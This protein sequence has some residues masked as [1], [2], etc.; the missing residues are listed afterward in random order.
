M[1]GAVLVGRNRLNPAGMVLLKHAWHAVHA[2]HSSQS[3]PLFTDN[4]ATPPQYAFIPDGCFLHSASSGQRLPAISTMGSNGRIGQVAELPLPA[5]VGDASLAEAI[6]LWSEKSLISTEIIHYPARYPV[7]GGRDA[8]GISA[9]ESVFDSLLNE[10]LYLVRDLLQAERARSPTIDWYEA[11][12]DLRMRSDDD[13]ARHSMV[14]ELAD[15]LL[16]PLDHV[17]SH[18]KKALKR[19]RENQR[20]QLVQEVDTHCLMD[21]ASRPGSTMPEKAG[22]K[23]RILAVMREEAVDLLENR[24]ARH[25]S[26]LAHRA[27]TRYLAA[28]AHIHRS[29][30]KDRVAKLLRACVRV[31]RKPQFAG[32]GRLNHPCRNPNYVLLQNVH[33]APIWQAYTKLI[34]N[35]ELR[36]TLWRWPR[37]LWADRVAI[38]LGETILHWTRQSGCAVCVNTA[39]RIVQART[40]N[41]H[42]RW[43]LHDIMP[44]PIVVGRSYDSVGSMYIIDGPLAS[45]IDDR[46]QE[47]SLLNADYL[48]FW[49]SGKTLNLLPVYAVWPPPSSGAGAASNDDAQMADDVLECVKIF[50]RQ[51]KHTV[52]IGTLLVRGRQDSNSQLS[53]WQTFQRH[54]STCWTAD[55]GPE[56]SSWPIND[57]GRYH[58][59]TSLVGGC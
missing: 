24:V 10:S 25:C 13:P 3:I 11:L 39:D 38:Y 47:S 32:V 22:P 31:P 21:L 18:P 53:E 28:H 2:V 20:V 16:V 34:R 14:V 59:L 49:V 9:Y 46:L 43:L 33:Y 52:A 41:L 4:P 1:T 51:A 36:D 15:S 54:G 42:G 30:R 23:Q 26:E 57:P 7:G 55:M 17:T 48:A 29:K 44:G 19:V 40:R 50:N 12:S 5:L 45:T 56:V 37:R 27:A 58:P 35:E 6:E 8:Q